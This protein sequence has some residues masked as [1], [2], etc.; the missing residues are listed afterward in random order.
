MENRRGSG[1]FLGIVGVATLVVAIIGATFAYFSASRTADNTIDVTA[2]EFNV[3]V[4]LTP[5]LPNPHS[6]E[7][8]I[9]LA[10]DATVENGEVTNLEHA[11]NTAGCLFNVKA[12]GDVGEGTNYQACALYKLTITNNG[13]NPISLKGTITSI[14]NGSTTG[15][16]FVN[17]K[18]RELV[19]A[20][21]DYLAPVGKIG[22]STEKTAKDL[23]EKN[24]IL[25]LNDIADL[26]AGETE[27]IFFVVYLN[28]DGADNN[29]EMGA[30][31]KGQVTYADPNTG[32]QLSATF[33]VAG[34]N[35]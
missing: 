14:E 9:P 19:V 7:K 30:I 13:A 34:A 23:P 22:L 35:E 8:L 10:A 3:A 33:S 4:D 5:V 20:E 31:Y 24:G 17:L 26:P 2:Y 1:I 18:Y 29:A 32:S 27:T 6:G 15:S 16:S 25:N 12:A 21:E 28:E 11:L